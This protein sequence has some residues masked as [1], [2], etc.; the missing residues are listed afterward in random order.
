MTTF[1][2]FLGIFSESPCHSQLGF[3]FSNPLISADLPGIHVS[4][5]DTYHV[6][7]IIPIMQIDSLLALIP[8]YSQVIQCKLWVT[9]SFDHVSAQEKVHQL[10]MTFVSHT[11]GNSGHPDISS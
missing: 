10:V 9:V 11:S 4:Y 3:W 5:A 7:E 2:N 8:I 1:L 6:S